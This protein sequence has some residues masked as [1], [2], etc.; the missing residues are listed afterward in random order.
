MERKR[1]IM[2]FV[3]RF[4]MQVSD[5]PVQRPAHGF[6]ALSLHALPIAESA[7]RFLDQRLRRKREKLFGGPLMGKGSHH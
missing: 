1:T 5:S 7:E 6:R 2:S 4:Y 3:F